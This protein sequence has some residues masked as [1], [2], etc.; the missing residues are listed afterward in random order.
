M[1]DFVKF[2]D[3]AKAVTTATG[4]PMYLTEWG[5]PD[6]S[7]SA[8]LFCRTCPLISMTTSTRLLLV[9]SKK[10]TFT[11]LADQPNLQYKSV[12]LLTGYNSASQGA[13]TESKVFTAF[14]STAAKYLGSTQAPADS[15]PTASADPVLKGSS[16]RVVSGLK[17][18][19]AYGEC[20]N[21]SGG[22]K[23]AGT[24]VVLYPCSKNRGYQ[25]TFFN[26]AAPTRFRYSVNFVWSPI[27]AARLFWRPA[28]EPRLK[29]GNTFPARRL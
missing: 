3:R 27:R 10:L 12:A 14:K 29:L 21:V 11:L 7:S 23:A 15:T 1:A 4:K 22:V 20:L 2:L 17:T 13:F 26:G 16:F 9:E 28:P 24:P 25:R 5:C 6:W 19:D 18:S 8:R